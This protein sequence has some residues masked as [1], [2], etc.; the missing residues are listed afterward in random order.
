MINRRLFPG[1]AVISLILASLLFGGL[2]TE[3]IKYTG[4][5]ANRTV[6]GSMHLIEIGGERI[7]LDAGSFYDNEGEEEGRYDKK[8]VESLSA[9]IISHA[10]TD[11]IGNLCKIINLGYAGKIYCTEPTKEIMPVMLEMASKYGY[12]GVES[13]YYSRA[14]EGRYKNVAVHLYSDCQYGSRISS[15]NFK[16]INMPRNELSR[17]NF[18]LCSECIQMEVQKIMEKVV[19]I[20]IGKTFTPAANVRAEF[21]LTPHIPGSAMVK[22]TDLTTEKTLLY[23]GDLGSELSPYLPPQQYPQ[24]INY[25]IFEATY[26][27]KV[28]PIPPEARGHFQKEIGSYL[29]EG[30][31]VIIPAFVL[32]RTQQVLYEL[33]VGMEEGHIPADTKIWVIGYSVGKLNRIYEEIFTKE[34]YAP[35]FSE[36]YQAKGPFGSI[37]THRNS[38]GTKQVRHGEVAIVSSGMA[39]VSYAN[40][41]V[42]EWHQDP[43]TV[44]VFVGYQSPD[45]PGG[46]LTTTGQIEI[47]GVL[48]DAKAEIVKFDCFSSHANFEQ[49]AELITRVGDVEEALIVH[50]NAYD[51]TPVLKAYQER[52][53]HIKFSIPRFKEEYIFGQQ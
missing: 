14:N 42:R 24:G 45:T 38:I 19:A 11:H 22:L 52:F 29:K 30:K 8:L 7:L 31:R 28:R 25:L 41:F 32:D 47:E 4:Y 21:F 33:T 3:A 36:L 27:A 20:P 49:I 34:K 37:F 17:E 1:I 50:L 46:Q 44:F 15:R 18:Y 35:Y 12:Y 2:Q 26:G 40:E 43:N 23:T 10:H 53:P 6:S 16:R 51:C 39:D 13:F 9:I 48:Q 5:G